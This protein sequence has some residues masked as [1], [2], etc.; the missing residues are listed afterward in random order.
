LEGPRNNL[1]RII[2]VLHDEL[3]NNTNAGNG[4]NGGSHHVVPHTS[5]NHN[6]H[7]PVKIVGCSAI[8]Y[9]EIVSQLTMVAREKIKFLPTPTDLLATRT[10]LPSLVESPK[11][12]VSSASGTSNF[13]NSNNTFSVFVSNAAFGSDGL[14]NLISTHLEYGTGTL[15]HLAYDAAEYVNHYSLIGQIH[16]NFGIRPSTILPSLYRNHQAY[17]GQILVTSSKNEDLPNLIR[18]GLRS[19]DVKVILVDMGAP[20]LTAYLK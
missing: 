12:T 2:D 1:E 5:R 10:L 11:R 15:V 17:E 4:F 8:E 14:N 19:P 16:R 9:M 18:N 3:H 7:L 13:V 6:N 20:N